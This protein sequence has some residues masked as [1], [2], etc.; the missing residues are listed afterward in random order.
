MTVASIC[1]DDHPIQ[2]IGREA[3][4]PLA[5]HRRVESY[6]D[7]LGAVKKRGV[8]AVGLDV[9]LAKAISE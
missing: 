3:A 8:Q 1:C 6:E 9:F 5:V 7:E 4:V 2:Q